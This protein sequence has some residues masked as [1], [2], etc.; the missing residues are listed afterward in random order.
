M[1]T[2]EAGRTAPDRGADLERIRMAL[3][4]GLEALEA[5]RSGH[6][7]VGR[8]AGGD[9]VTDADHAVDETL[10]RILPRDGEGWL[11]EE[12]ADDLTRLEARRVWVVDPLDGT[13]EFVQGLP[14][15]CIS[16]GLVEDGEAVAAG[17][18]NPATGETFLG[19]LG[20]GVTLNGRPVAV[21]ELQGLEGAEVLASR[22]E[23]RR[24]EWEDAKAP[25]RVR[26]CGSVAYKM[27]L[28]AAGLTDATWTLTPKHE[29]DVAAGAALV[30]AAGGIVRTLSWDPPVFNGRDPWLSGLIATPPGI[31]DAVRRYIGNP[32]PKER[33]QRRS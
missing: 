20:G 14:E 30:R 31:F 23:V 4:A 27:A 2:T 28:V 8:K 24:R 12:T 29:W 10:R 33:R 21:R 5:V 3:A 16:I 26:P 32:Q 15:W 7:T 1:A 25:F 9:L 6:V 13:Q 18:C 11:S 17:L 22:S 19:A